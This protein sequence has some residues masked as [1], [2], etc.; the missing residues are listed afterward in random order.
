MTC[1]MLRGQLF[2]TAMLGVLAAAL[3]CRAVG[4]RIETADGTWNVPAT[5]VA[6]VAGRHQAARSSWCRPMSAPRCADEAERRIAWAAK[7]PFRRRNAWT[8]RPCSALVD[9]QNPQVALARERIAEAYAQ[10]DRADYLWLPSLR[11]GLNYNKHEGAI[12]DV[13]GRVFDT[14]RGDF[15][16]GL[17]AAAVGAASPAVPGVW[18][19]FHLADACFQPKIAEHEASARSH[20][21]QATRNAFLRDAAV[22]YW[23]LVRA[24]HQ[25]AVAQ[26]TLQNTQQLARLTEAY[27]RTGQGLKADQQRLEAELAVRRSELLQ[28]GRGRPRGVGATGPAAGR[29]PA[30]PDRDRRASGRAARTDRCR[31]ARRGPGR[32]GP[33]PEA[34]TGGKPALGLLRL[35][36]VCGASVSP[37]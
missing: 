3:G 19:N 32:A 12:Q 10:C 7:R 16:G 36:S 28:I 24:E 22:A 5:V 25:Q 30:V 11:T 1:E 8:W 31:H 6:A 35:A 37:R 14:S 15:Y 13:A 9:G 18:A 33:Q 21:A 23:E 26:E 34:G 17:G 27:A 2:C 20:A 29:R 4:T